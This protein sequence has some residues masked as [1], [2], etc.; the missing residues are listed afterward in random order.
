MQYIPTIGPDK[1]L[2]TIVLL[3]VDSPVFADQK[4]PTSFVGFPF[5]SELRMRILQKGTKYLNIG[6][7][8]DFGGL[9]DNATEAAK[10]IEDAAFASTLKVKPV[11]YV[12]IVSLSLSTLGTDPDTIYCSDMSSMEE[13]K[14]V[15]SAISVALRQ[16]GKTIE[17]LEKD[18]KVTLSTDIFIKSTGGL[19]T[20]RVL[21]GAPLANLLKYSMV[22]PE[23]RAFMNAL[24]DAYVSAFRQIE[25]QIPE[26][27]EPI[28]AEP[29]QPTSVSTKE[30][31]KGEDKDTPATTTYSIINV[32]SSYIGQNNYATLS[33]IY[34]KEFDTS[35]NNGKRMNGEQPLN[36]KHELDT[37]LEDN[38]S[39]IIASLLTKERDKVLAM[40]SGSSPNSNTDEAFVEKD[41]KFDSL[42][43]DAK[44]Y[45]SNNI[46][47]GTQLKAD[48]S[49]L[50]YGDRNTQKPTASGMKLRYFNPYLRYQSISHQYLISKGTPLKE[51]D[52]SR[53]VDSNLNPPDNEAR[54]KLKF[55]PRVFAWILPQASTEFKQNEIDISQWVT[56]V[57]I[58]SSIHTNQ[59][60]QMSLSPVKAKFDRDLGY[61]KP[62]E[63]KGTVESD[64]LFLDRII[65]P[66]D[67]IFIKLVDTRPLELLVMDG[68]RNEN[69]V[70]AEFHSPRDT[71]IDFVGLV[72]QID[73][74]KQAPNSHTLTISGTDISSFLLDENVMYL[75]QSS[76]T[77]VEISGNAQKGIIVPEEVEDLKTRFMN[78][79]IKRVPMSGISEIKDFSQ[80]TKSVKELLEII[81]EKLK[82]LNQEYYSPNT[83]QKVDVTK[84]IMLDFDPDMSKS[85]A[86][87]QRIATM[88][89]SVRNFIDSITPQQFYEKFSITQPILQEQTL[90]ALCAQ[91]NA[92]WADNFV[93]PKGFS[94][95]QRVHYMIR[96]APMSFQS[97]KDL[98]VF[99]VPPYL[100]KSISCKRSTSDIYTS[101]RVL[102]SSTSATSS[103]AT[104]A[105]FPYVT[106]LT[107]AKKYG[108]KTLVVNS[109]FLSLTKGIAETK[110]DA[111]TLYDAMS[112]NFDLKRLISRYIGQ[113]FY[114]SG[115][116]V[117]A[118]LKNIQPGCIIEFD[119][120]IGD[121]TERYQAYIE[122]VSQSRNAKYG[123]STT[124]ISFT[125]GAT[126]KVHSLIEQLVDFGEEQLTVNGD[127]DN[128][129]IKFN[130]GIF[131]ELLKHQPSV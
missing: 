115:Q 50:R 104:M 72:Q 98:E 39:V 70:K 130:L 3:D 85:L 25:D 117:T 18:S 78:E 86:Y 53:I 84:Q 67:L 109:S 76:G 121:S 125:R 120:F 61:W 110:E 14:I 52:F 83:L 129:D 27:I 28:E 106:F 131:N 12:Y 101:F 92:L 113:A 8:D 46:P 71:D 127:K 73:K 29:Q 22:T 40:L 47:E 74:V 102:P 1:K 38:Y 82:I 60:F 21:N 34:D 105:E 5:L 64:A 114:E 97:F 65:N 42:S 26:D 36:K 2:K 59:A 11:K 44:N 63:D 16:L 95:D 55:S 10:G 90:I 66:G 15:S 54:S 81:L 79:M 20:I 62:L 88:Q 49:K 123:G 80:N 100:V 96:Y 48:S 87:N 32:D 24:A 89:G 112:G 122:S 68:S 116:I 58:Q 124:T 57:S 91:R 103:G 56:S 51:V 37:L 23:S 75:T 111:T 118:P 126:K 107:L 19:P 30:P 77:A 13:G 6:L 33:D 45:L 9:S 17:P 128:S 7:L 69:T 4:H 119:M 94:L 99:Y 31:I 43:V 41:F 108:L 93:K 35:N